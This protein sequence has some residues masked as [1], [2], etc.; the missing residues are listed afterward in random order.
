MPTSTGRARRPQKAIGVVNS[1]SIAA[2]PK[3]ND[4]RTRAFRRPADRLGH[5]NSDDGG[6]HKRGSSDA[7]CWPLLPRLRWAMNELVSGVAGPRRTGP[8]RILSNADLALRLLYSMPIERR[9]K[10]RATVQVVPL[11]RNGS[12]TS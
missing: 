3:A 10:A 1:G 8:D 6:T 5:Y 4:A 12:R 2:L 7:L 11:P 9:R